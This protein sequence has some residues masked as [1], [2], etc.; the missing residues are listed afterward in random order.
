[1]ELL[2]DEYF[3]MVLTQDTGPQYRPPNITILIIGIP[4][5]STPQFWQTLNPKPSFPLPEASLG[6][7]DLLAHAGTGSLHLVG[8]PCSIHVSLRA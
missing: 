6:L 7:Y 4:Q 5:T 8:L 1:M 3:Q 2:M